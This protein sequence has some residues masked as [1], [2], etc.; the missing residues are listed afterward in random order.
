M[1]IHIGN[2]YNS[3]NQGYNNFDEFINNKQQQIDIINKS[4]S[5]DDRTKALGRLKTNSSILINAADP[6]VMKSYDE[7]DLKTLV[8]PNQYAGLITYKL[9][10]PDKYEQAINILK[11]KIS[12]LYNIHLSTDDMKN[13]QSPVA[14]SP[15][16]QT[17]DAAVAAKN[18]GTLA[19][20]TIDQQIGQETIKRQLAKLGRENLYQQLTR[21]QYKL[22]NEFKNTQNPNQK[23]ELVQQYNNNQ[24]TINNVL[25]ESKADDIK[26][27]LT[28]KLKFDQQVKE[29]TQDEEQGVFGYGLNRFMKSLY[30]TGAG[31]DDIV[32]GL[33]GGKDANTKLQMQRLGEAKEFENMMYLP[34]NFRRTGSPEILQASENLKNKV[35]EITGGKSMSNWASEERTKVNDVVAKNQDEIKTITNSEAGKSK[36]FLTKATGYE[37]AGFTGDVAS[38]MMQVGALK[39]IGL[40]AKVAEAGQLF[41]NAYSENYNKATEEGMSSSQAHKYG[42]LHGGVMALAGLVNSKFENVQKILGGG[43]SALSKEIAGL[44]EAGWKAIL[45]KSPSITSKVLNSAKSVIG[46]NAKNIATFGVGTSIVNDLVDNG[47][48]N[49]NISTDE[50]INHAIQ[51]AKDMAVGSVALAGAGF[52]S[53]IAKTPITFK[54]KTDIWEL[55]DNPDINKSRIDESIAKGE[56]STAEGEAR[57]KAITNISSLIEKVPIQNDKGKLLTDQQKVEYLYNSVVKNKAKEAISDLPPKQAE[58]AEMTGMV[59]EY[60]NSILLDN[61]TDKQLESRKN[62][63]E[64][65]LEPKKGAEGKTIEPNEKEVKE[66]KAELEAINDIIENKPKEEDTH[67]SEKIEGIDQTTGIPEGDNV[68]APT[69]GK[70]DAEIENRMAELED[71][72][73]KN[74]SAEQKEYDLLEKELE[75]REKDKIFNSP[76]DKVKDVVDELMKKEKEMPNGYG[77]FMEKRDAMETKEVVDRYLNAKGLTD[78]ELKKDFSDAVRGNPTTWYA[79]GL[80]MREALKEASNRGIDTKDMLAEVTKVYTDAGYDIQ[81]A[82]SV[83]AGMIKPVFEDS[84]TIKNEAK[85]EVPKNTIQ[86]ESEGTVNAKA[87]EVEQPAKEGGQKPPVGE[88][89]LLIDEKSDGETTS[90]KNEVTKNERLKKGLGEVEVEAKR[91]F[92]DVYEKGKK[93]VEDGDIEP[94]VLAR[95]L[96]KKPRALKPEESV[97]LLYDRMRLHN[98]HKKLMGDIMEAKDKG[99]EIKEDI[100]RS[101][102]SQLEQDMTFNDEAS[103]RTGYEQGLG[104]AIRKLMI[105]EDYSLANQLTRF[106]IAN[107]GEE[108]PYET[109]QNLEALTIRLQDAEKKITEYE[110]RIKSLEAEKEVNKNKVKSTKKTDDDFKKERADIKKSMADKLKKSRGDISATILPYAKEL[111][112]ISPDIAKLVKS[113]AEQGVIKLSEIIDNIHEE[114]KPL[115]PQITKKDVTDLIAGEYKEKKVKIIDRKKMSL[116]AD[117]EKVKRQID[118]EREKI[119]LS[120]RNKGEKAIDFFHKW[121]RFA[122]LSGV[123]VL[124]KLGMAAT[125]RNLITPIESAIGSGLNKIPGIKQIAKG[126]PREG[127]GFNRKAEAAAFSQWVDKATYKDMREIIKTGKGELDYLHDSKLHPPPDWTEFFGQLHAAIKALPKRSEFFRSVE[128]RG[129][130][131]LKNGKDLTDPLVQQ[132]VTLAAYNDAMRAIFMQD[133]YITDAYKSAITS[134]EKSNIPGSGRA[135][136]I[137]KFLFPIIKVPTNYVAEQSSYMIGGL[138]A[139]YALRKGLKNMTPDQKDYVMRAFKKQAIGAAFIAIGYFNPQAVGGYYSGK[140]DEGD[141][142]AGDLKLFGVKLPHWMA[143]TPLLECLQLGATFRRSSDDK[144]GTAIKNTLDGV[145][146]QIPFVSQGGQMS[147]AMKNMDNFKK[148]IFRT[149]QSVIEPQLMKEAA[150]FTEYIMD[151]KVEKKNPKTFL[152]QLETGVPGLRSNVESKGNDEFEEAAKK[153][154]EKENKKR[155]MT[156]EEREKEQIEKREKEIINKERDRK[157]KEAKQKILEKEGK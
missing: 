58:K 130:H 74:G 93:M 29:I 113:Y 27:P 31:I 101:T 44:G 126:A 129:E 109:R 26:Y 100:L 87:R 10:E 47:F 57:K 37:V 143:H 13:F 60:K 86:A 28:A 34:E 106:K 117:L 144:S 51:S 48:F 92:G 59:A 103:R 88:G 17:G 20:E 128:I 38:F 149:G 23:N 114:L 18:K 152:E 94:R 153:Q 68:P 89:K 4:L 145:I 24:N 16:I 39:G 134:L 40:G 78:A 148:Y 45:E 50:I 33:F 96:S 63:L 82:K 91:N 79:D 41:S 98:A 53:H 22:E 25:L 77:A 1:G 105:K 73:P 14:A 133:N 46:E 154:I 71:S 7:S 135:A 122:L 141:L 35:K 125:T 112:A 111:I 150:E 108:I 52:L 146:G 49:K 137:M 118:L 95:E 67:Q 3:L 11:A 56:I 42:M 15:T 151:G 156:D 8:D 90:I 115:I 136:N 43:K 124:G 140:R 107:N 65:S 72:R 6:A 142:E 84:K 55:G 155:S 70:T 110:D 102:L 75:K 131:A 21:E 120:K 61:P 147:T 76:L 30:G 5:G 138:K 132:E 123:K 85:A 157:I 66:A 54:D 36:N 127:G 80:K 32:I 81:T 64:K 12:P 99:D 121:R 62:A 139:A 9:F 2:I 119:K 83:V 19:Q 104:L 97:A 69:I 116:Q